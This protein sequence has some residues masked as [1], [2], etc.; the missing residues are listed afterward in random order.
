MRTLQASFLEIYNES[1]RDLLGPDSKEEGR[2]L[3]IRTDKEGEMC[4]PGARTHART[5]EGHTRVHARTGTCPTS[6][7]LMSRAAPTWIGSWQSLPRTGQPLCAA[8]VPATT[9]IARRPTRAQSRSP[10]AAMCSSALRRF[11]G[12]FGTA[13]EASGRR[14]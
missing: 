1:I 3:A 12:A 6:R 8:G 7:T 4:V 10:M 13:A 9:A 11:M 14:R 5:H 2:V